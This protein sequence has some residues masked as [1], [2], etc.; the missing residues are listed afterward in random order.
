MSSWRSTCPQRE[1]FLFFPFLAFFALGE[2]L[3]SFFLLC[4]FSF[5]IQYVL[6]FILE[7]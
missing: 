6:L 2:V 5:S 7:K 3:R 4:H 1:S